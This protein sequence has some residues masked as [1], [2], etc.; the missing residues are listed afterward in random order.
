MSQPPASPPAAVSVPLRVQQAYASGFRLEVTPEDLAFL[1]GLALTGEIDATTEFD[2]ATLMQ[3]HRSVDEV[4]GALGGGGERAERA[5]GRLI[6]QRLLTRLDFGGIRHGGTYTLSALARALLD[7]AL[8]P[9]RL[10]RQS[11]AVVL[12]SVLAHLTEIEAAARHDADP[13]HWAAQVEAPLRLVVHELI[14]AIERRQHALDAEQ[15][16]TRQAI[17]ALLDAD[18]DSALERCGPLLNA[19]AGTLRELREAMF[20]Q[21]SLLNERLEAIE[22]AALA[23]GHAAVAERAAGL[24]LRLGTVAQWCQSRFERWGEYTRTVNEFIRTQV[25]FDRGRSVAA[26]LAEALRGYAEAPWA[27]VVNDAGQLLRLRPEAADPAADAHAATLPDEAEGAPAHTD[28]AL[29][30]RHAA[31]AAALDATLAGGGSVSLAGLLAATAAD[32]PL[33]LRYAL[34]ARLFAH[35][36]ARHPQAACE[37]AAAPVALG[38]RLQVEDLQLTPEAR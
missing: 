3:V 15:R 35:A 17:Q 36:L 19:A 24:L 10:D 16:D 2:L 23:G 6:E 7:H 29:D 13:A 18:W 5:V 27:L 38:A 31:L 30:A 4:V 1:A 20:E 22:S 32:A 34:Y 14:G 21:T 9:E 12:G 28:A 25:R 33:D 26:R 11:L 8:G 37:P